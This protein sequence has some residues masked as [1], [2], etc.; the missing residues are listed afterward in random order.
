[1]LCR[2]QHVASNAA[3]IHGLQMLVES[4]IASL[5]IVQERTSVKLNENV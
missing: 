2:A 1:M 3:E 5:Y 4:S